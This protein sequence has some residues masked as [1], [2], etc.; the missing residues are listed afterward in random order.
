VS[1]IRL[2]LIVSATDVHRICLD[3]FV[4]QNR[5]TIGHALN[6]SLHASDGPPAP[7]LIRQIGAL[8][9]PFEGHAQVDGRDYLIAGDGNQTSAVEAWA[10]TSAEMALPPLRC[11]GSVDLVRLRQSEWH[12][13]F[14]ARVREKMGDCD[15]AVDGSTVAP[16]VRS[17]ISAG[18]FALRPIRMA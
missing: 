10:A 12:A 7:E 1:T 14:L 16:L 2:S 17:S 11:D 13:K 3:G 18:R 4:E 9:I 8:G 15:W 5:T 6:I